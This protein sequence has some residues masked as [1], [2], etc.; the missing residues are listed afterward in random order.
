M[1]KHALISSYTVKQYKVEKT[2]CNNKAIRN[3][4]DRHF[5]NRESL[6]ACVSDLTYVRVGNSW[7]YICAIIDLN[8]RE[9]I[10]YSVGKKKC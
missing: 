9:I 6:E 1:K 8:N 4:V 10:G 3:K 5:N 2:T 7:N